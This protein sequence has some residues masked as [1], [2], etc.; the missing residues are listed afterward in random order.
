MKVGSNK[1]GDVYKYY[2]ERLLPLY[3][4]VEARSLIL[5]LMEEY[6]PFERSDM[7]GYPEK[8]ISE[9]SLLRIHKAV[10]KLE[11][12]R[13]VQYITERAHFYGCDFYVNEKVLIPR[14]ETEE[15]VDWVLKD[16]KGQRGKMD[17]LDVGTGSGCI[18][19]A[20]KKNL[21]ASKMYALD[22]D[23]DVLDIAVKNSTR[24]KVEI[25]PITCNV[26]EEGDDEKIPDHLDI[27]IS[28]PPY[29]RECEKNLMKQNVL[30]YEPGA[31]LFVPD[32]DPLLYYRAILRI[33]ARHLK[34]GGRM[35]F[36]IN[37]GLADAV[38]ELLLAY[39]YSDIMIRK[40]LN[41]KDRMARAIKDY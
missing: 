19:I 18:S 7:L 9:S 8:P 17:I 5:I 16:T 14:P 40:D 2:L 25:I 6:T 36:E 11:A 10:K 38:R 13:P 35:F 29:I 34:I 27:V 15:L 23:Q 41:G 39:D 37:E 1:L 12:F 28:N 26:L 31:A 3:D 20:L 30:D 33:A 4:E 32:D 24:N 22:F 21:P